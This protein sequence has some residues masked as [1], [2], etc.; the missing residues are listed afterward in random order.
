[1]VTAIY[2]TM[3][4]LGEGIRFYHTLPIDYN[5][6]FGSFAVQIKYTDSPTN[7]QMSERMS[8]IKELFPDYKV[9]TGGG[10]VKEMIGEIP[11]DDMIRVIVIVVLCINAMVAVLMVKSFITKEKGEIGML[12]AIGFRNSAIVHWQILRI[13]IILLIATVLGA[14]LSNPLAQI[15][16]GA[17]FKMM[18][19][20]SIEFQVDPLEVYLIYPLLVFAVTMLSSFFTAQQIRKISA[21]ETSNIE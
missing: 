14:L 1:M 16:S 4:N 19:A 3:N 18:G 13:G 20:S 21:S 15:S 6:A 17:I 2:Q 12:K 8:K 9:Y 10:Y 7:S 11:M 5:L